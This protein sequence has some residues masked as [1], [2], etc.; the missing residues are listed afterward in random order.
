MHH[1]NGT[2]DIFEEDKSVLYLSIHRY[3]GGTFYPNTGNLTEV[4]YG[5]AVES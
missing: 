1:G 5:Y 2:Q 4:R 3:Q